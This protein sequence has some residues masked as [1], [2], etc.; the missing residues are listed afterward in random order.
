MT[1]TLRP[2]APEEH[3][4]DGGRR[5]A[6]AITVNGRPV[7][8]LRLETDA[9]FAHRVGRL[10]DLTVEPAERRRGRGTVAALAAEEVLRSWGCGQADVA[11][12]DTATG[13]LRL[14]AALGYA[15]RWRTLA[16]ELADPP[17]PPPEDSAHRPLTEAEYQPWL[18]AERASYARSWTERGVPPE[19][20]AF[21]ANA[22]TEAAL[23]QGLATAGV[24]VHVLEHAG[25][26]VGSCWLTRTHEGARG[27]PAVMG[28]SVAP[29]HRGLGHGHTLLA[30][31][32]RLVAERG[33]KRLLAHAFA[34]NLPASRLAA[35]LD[36]R[37][38]T[39]HLSKP[40]L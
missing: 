1:T 38:L 15:A 6:F 7:G 37:P 39:H 28:V 3:T 29:E 26:P 9:R 25:T 8:A 5:R 27:E 14:A 18:A 36:Y 23:P 31:A 20:A 17:P 22:A 24:L 2:T 10:V 13:A 12:P 4:D 34:G 35:S 40:L 19:W 21:R 32:E 30:H 33:A 11:V 16:K